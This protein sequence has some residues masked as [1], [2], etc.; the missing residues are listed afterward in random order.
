MRYT[1]KVE[2][3]LSNMRPGYQRRAVR[4][5]VTTVV[6][7]RV[8]VR[9]FSVVKTKVDRILTFKARGNLEVRFPLLHLIFYILGARNMRTSLSEVALSQVPV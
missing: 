6:T 1:I 2:I 8:M 3:M 9:R 5:T 7:L 4:S